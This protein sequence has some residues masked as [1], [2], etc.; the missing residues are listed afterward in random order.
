MTPRRAWYVLAAALAAVLSFVTFL[1]LYEDSGSGEPSAAPVS[2]P[3]VPW[4]GGPR[5]YARF[6]AM[7]AAGWTD[8]SFFPIGVWYE[9]VTSQADVDLDKGAGLNTYFEL[10]T[11]SKIE[12]VRDNGMFAVPSHQPPGYGRETVGWLLTD[13]VDL[14]AHEGDAPWTGNSPGQG[15]ICIPESALC[16]Y[17]VL[18]TLRERL[19]PDDGRARYANFGFGMEFFIPEPLAARFLDYTDVASMDTYWYTDEGMCELSKTPAAVCRTAAS[20][21]FTVD[22]IRHLDGLDGKRQPIYAFVEVGFPF[23]KFD[24]EIAPAELAGAV[25]NSLIHEARGVIYFNHNFGSPCV[26]QHVLRDACGARI[27]P[28]VTEVNRRITELAP[29]LNTQSISHTFLPGMDTMLKAHGDAYYVFAMPGRGLAPGRHTLTL[30]P[31]MAAERAEVLWENRALPAGDGRITDDFPAE[32][33]YR[34]YR[35][36]R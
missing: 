28:A 36:P 16:G 27:R 9:A 1:V 29:V 19:P 3:L 18:R 7:A 21:G 24:T 11:S 14:W 6:P 2:L 20:Y 30:P 32:H 22:R 10:T 23:E 13:E 31:G 33:S 17:T 12:L 4:E 35:I 8:P 26:S 15:Q 25:M 34:V 5:Y